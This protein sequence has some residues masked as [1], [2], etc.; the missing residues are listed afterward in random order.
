MAMNINWQEL[1]SAI[2]GLVNMIVQLLPVLIMMRI[3]QSL[4][5]SF[6]F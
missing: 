1:T 5:W 6:T 2:E 3:L 4:L